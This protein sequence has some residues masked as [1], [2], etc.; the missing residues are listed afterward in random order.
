AEVVTFETH[1]NIGAGAT[2]RA[3][4]KLAVDTDAKV[5][6]LDVAE[7]FSGGFGLY[8]GAFAN[9]SNSDDYKPMGISIT[10][11]SI[12]DIG[13]GATLTGDTVDLTALISQLH[14]ASHAGAEAFIILLFGAS[15]AYAEADIDSTTN[16]KVNIHG[17][18]SA[19]TD[20][21]N[22]TGANGVDIRALTYDV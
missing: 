1:A 9:H 11:N 17:D 16:A 20:V 8:A 5:N 7:A 13:K 2:L 18:S 21:T 6:A 15:A 14:A 12:V 19:T 3:G 22:I 10:G 4:G